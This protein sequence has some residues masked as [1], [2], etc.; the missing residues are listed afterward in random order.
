MPSISNFLEIK[1]LL[2]VACKTAS[3]MIKTP[4]DIQKRFA[5]KNDTVL[6]DERQIR[7]GN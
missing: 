5:V 3:N 6:A 2:Y 4:E 7:E 1:G